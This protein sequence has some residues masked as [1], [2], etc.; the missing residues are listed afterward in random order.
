LRENVDQGSTPNSKRLQK[1][2][3]SCRSTPLSKA[4]GAKKFIGDVDSPAKF[5]QGRKINLNSPAARSPTARYSSP[6]KLLQSKFRSEV[7]SPSVKSFLDIDLDS[8]GQFLKNIAAEL[9]EYDIDVDFEENMTPSPLKHNSLFDDYTENE[10]NDT[11]CKERPPDGSP[12][13]QTNLLESPLGCA[14][15][16]KTLHCI[17]RARRWVHRRAPTLLKYVCGF[18][19]VDAAGGGGAVRHDLIGLELAE[20]E[21]QGFSLSSPSYS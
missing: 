12:T 10:L 16:G 7:G 14:D 9:K 2:P 20:C 21:T 8:P 18:G 3:S 11:P 4:R 15:G 13:E 6:A 17:G 1:K 19:G 5:L